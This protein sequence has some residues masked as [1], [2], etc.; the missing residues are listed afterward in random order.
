MTSPWRHHDVTMTLS[1]HHHG[2]TMTLPWRHHDVTMTSPWL[3]HEVTMTLPWRRHDVTMTLPWRHGDVTMRRHD[4]MENF[5]LL[6]LVSDCVTDDVIYQ[7]G[8]TWHPVVEPLGEIPCVTCSCVVGSISSSYSLLSTFF[9][10]TCQHVH[11]RFFL[12]TCQH[13]H[14]RLFV[15]TCQ[16]VHTRFQA[17]SMA[18]QTWEK[19]ESALGLWKSQGWFW[20]TWLVNRTLLVY[21]SL[22]WQSWVTK[23]IQTL[24]PQQLIIDYWL[25][26]IVQRYVIVIAVH[27]VNPIPKIVHLGEKSVHLRGKNVYIF[28]GI[29][30]L[31][32]GQ[33][34]TEPLVADNFESVATY[35]TNTPIVSLLSTPLS[36]SRR[37]AELAVVQWISTVD[38]R[39]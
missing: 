6:F 2:V 17:L 24:E 15:L 7:N 3:H 5:Q 22:T 12:L 31:Y 10:L 33:S 4:I 19:K 20:W 37:S 30:S 1:W 25:P 28:G 27:Y 39:L 9:L 14:A 34:L 13:V 23:S 32:V 35:A 29:H 36:V 11:T 21:G 18:K 38:A 8:S 26:Y 16:Y